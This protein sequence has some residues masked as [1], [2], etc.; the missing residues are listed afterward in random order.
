MPEQAPSAPFFDDAR[1][2]WTDLGGGLSRKILGWTDALMAVCVK[3]DKGAAGAPHSHD[4]HDQIAYVVRGR[5]EIEIDGQR[6]ELGPGDAFTVAK[7]TRHGARA[8]EQGSMLIDIFSPRRDDF[9]S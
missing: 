1:T 9:L 8:L 5:F 2:E 6:R 4:V 7:H 3:F